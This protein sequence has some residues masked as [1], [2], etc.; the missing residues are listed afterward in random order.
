MRKASVKRGSLRKAELQAVEAWMDDRLVSTESLLSLRESEILASALPQFFVERARTL[1][2]QRQMQFAERELE[3]AVDILEHRDKQRPTD[4]MIEEAFLGD[5]SEAYFLL[6]AARDVRGDSMGALET[7][8]QLRARLS[9]SPVAPL[10]SDLHR[11]IPAGTVLFSYD[12]LDDEVLIH[13][14]DHDGIHRTSVPVSAEHRKRLIAALGK[15]SRIAGRALHR[16]LIAPVADVVARAK[17]IVIVRDPA[18]EQIPFAALLQDNGRYLALD[19][20]SVITPSIAWYLKALHRRVSMSRALLAVGNPALDERFNSLPGLTAA[21]NEAETIAAMYPSRAM[22][23]GANA[24]KERVIG[25]L[26]YCDAAHFAVHAVAAGGG[27]PSSFLRLTSSRGDDGKLFASDI[28][29]LKLS[30]VRTVVLAAC[31][32]AVASPDLRYS[33]SLTDAFLKA[34][35]GSVVGSLWEIEDAPTRDLS[36]AFHRALRDGLTPAEALRAAQIEMIAKSSNNS[37]L[38]WAS[39][40]VYGSGL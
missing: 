3:Q 22:L 21:E 24:T 28:A 26:A 29:A 1:Q 25:A 9:E 32:T 23:L 20:A 37:T 36:I 14:I 33:Q 38:A 15:G 10:P 31:R 19:H 13:A 17:T 2:H 8:E 35:A 30:G 12:V 7:L 16:I 27:V 34:G 5:P 40:Q 39:L 6:A 11:E 4:P 18:L